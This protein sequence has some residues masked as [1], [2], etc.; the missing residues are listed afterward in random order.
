MTKDVSI[1]SSLLSKLDELLGG[2]HTLY[3]NAKVGDAID[4]W[5][6]MA[7]SF[8][9]ER[10]LDATTGRCLSLAEANA[11]H[12]GV[13]ESSDELARGVVIVRALSEIDIA[14][15]VRWFPNR[16]LDGVTATEEEA[17]LQCEYPDLQVAL[18]IV[19]SGLIVPEFA[20]GYFAAAKPV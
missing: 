4:M 17:A 18:G 3:H 5:N 15:A 12:L 16:A 11:R 6:L 13:K 10:Y 2:G 14:R 8:A 9:P 7:R 1:S 20:Q 19:G